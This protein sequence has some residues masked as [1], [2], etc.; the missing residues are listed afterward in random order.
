MEGLAC[1][2]MADQAGQATETF[3]HIGPA[4]RKKDARRWTYVDHAWRRRCTN[5][6]TG[7]TAKPE[8]SWTINPSGKR[9][10]AAVPPKPE[11]LSLLT[12]TNRGRRRLSDPTP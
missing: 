11:M 8:L 4:A 5:C 10:C 9:I 7:S 12:A 1:Q 2:R 3:A 6:A